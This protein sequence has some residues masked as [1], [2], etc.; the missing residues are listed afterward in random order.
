MHKIEL[1]Y[2]INST[3]KILFYKVS[4]PFGLQEWFADKITNQ[5]DVFAIYWH[6]TQ[7]LAKITTNDLDEVQIFWMDD[8]EKSPLVIS[9]KKTEITNE[10]ILAITDFYE[11]DES[12]II[13]FWNLKIEK[14]RTILGAR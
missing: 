9:I 4:T 3:H 10:L 11:D 2:I 6:K 5:D 7:N 14:L 12:E 8:K 1:E 13:D